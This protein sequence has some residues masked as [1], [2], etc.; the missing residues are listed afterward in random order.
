MA[1]VGV[2]G[3]GYVGLTLSI[4]AAKKGLNVYGIENN[5]DTLTLI[6]S[7]KAHFFEK[8]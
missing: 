6:K 5:K 8:D 2:I 7:G 3:L 4:I 1:N